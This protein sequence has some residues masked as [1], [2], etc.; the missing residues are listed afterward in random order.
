VDL[1]GAWG[2]VG[3][4]WVSRYLPNHQLN[5]T[6][7]TD[8]VMVSLRTLYSVPNDDLIPTRLKFQVLS[9]SGSKV[10]RR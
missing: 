8:L 7:L 5:L 10:L 9:V 4:Y 3:V 1:A 2:S 6:L